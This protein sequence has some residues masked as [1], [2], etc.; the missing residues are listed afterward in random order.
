MANP[1]DGRLP[2]TRRSPYGPAP[3]L[4]AGDMLLAANIRREHQMPLALDG[5]YGG[6]DSN[7]RFRDHCAAKTVQRLRCSAARAGVS[8]AGQ[9]LH[10]IYFVSS[11]SDGDEIRAWQTVWSSPRPPCLSVIVHTVQGWIVTRSLKGMF[12]SQGCLSVSGVQYTARGGTYHCPGNERTCCDYG[13]RF[14]PQCPA[15]TDIFG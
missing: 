1:S 13:A 10:P 4:R 5:M 3:C 2:A 12:L 14:A 7:G 6:S 9:S 11:G 8:A 15:A